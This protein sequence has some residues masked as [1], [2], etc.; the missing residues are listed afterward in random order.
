MLQHSGYIPCRGVHT[1]Q[2][3]VDLD[4]NFIEGECMLDVLASDSVGSSGGR[5]DG[6]QRRRA[7]VRAERPQFSESQRGDHDR[8][9]LQDLETAGATSTQEAG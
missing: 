5:G 6:I 8:S 9:K 4:G 7:H 1:L 2:Q 3:F